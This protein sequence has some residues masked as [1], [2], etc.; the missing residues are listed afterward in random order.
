[1]AGRLDLAEARAL[2]ALPQD[3]LL[4]R[5]GA[6][7]EDIDDGYAYEG[8]QGLSVL[9]RPE[10]FPGRIY[11]RDGRP[12]VIYVSG[13]GGWTEA[14]LQAELGGPGAELRSRAG[15]TST[16]HAYPEQGVAFSSDGDEVAFIE[17]FPPRP[18]ADYERDIYREPGPFIR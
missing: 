2:L 12:Q 16:Q 11:L 8:L 6:S 5:L 17:V 18:L 9:F 7:A 10:A 4:A 13:D 14:G 1:M 15:K 3:E